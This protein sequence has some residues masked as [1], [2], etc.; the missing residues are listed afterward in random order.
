M[1]AA[2]AAKKTLPTPTNEKVEAFAAYTPMNA[3]RIEM[4]KAAMKNKRK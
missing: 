4:M 2:P 3:E 1:S